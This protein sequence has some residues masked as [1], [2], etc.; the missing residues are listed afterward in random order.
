MCLYL[1]TYMYAVYMYIYVHIYVYIYVYIKSMT[2]I[3]SFV[4]ISIVY[5]NL[6]NHDSALIIT[7]V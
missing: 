6:F 1:Y 2:V 5:N 4:D 3:K 7:D